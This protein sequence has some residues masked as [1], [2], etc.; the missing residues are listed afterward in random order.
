MSLGP[1]GFDSELNESNANL[2]DFSEMIRSKSTANATMFEE[3]DQGPETVRDD[4]GK[5]LFP[6]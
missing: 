1:D 2:N 5:L 3:E 4:E 6:G